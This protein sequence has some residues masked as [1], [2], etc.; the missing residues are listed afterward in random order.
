MLHSYN[1]TKVEKQLFSRTNKI[2][3]KWS[4]HLAEQYES[5]KKKIV[6]G[7]WQIYEYD[8]EVQHKV[9]IGV[10]NTMR[11]SKVFI[12]GEYYSKVKYL[13]AIINIGFTN[14]SHA[15]IYQLN[16]NPNIKT[17]FNQV[18]NKS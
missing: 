18:L 10:I 14:Y 3:S 12:M 7:K 8:F 5:K 17:E 9:N 4:N 6:N 2:P 15:Q 1:S 16:Q 13:N 11:Y